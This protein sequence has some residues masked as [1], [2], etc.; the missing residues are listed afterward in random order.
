MLFGKNPRVGDRFK[1][2]CQDQL[3]V[4]VVEGGF[5]MVSVCGAVLV[6]V[7]SLRLES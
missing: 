5:V 3:L 6:V 7:L 4:N 2:E 1:S